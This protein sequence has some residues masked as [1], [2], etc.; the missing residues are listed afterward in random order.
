MTGSGGQIVLG[1]ATKFSND[2]GWK[3]SYTKGR[4]DWVQSPTGRVLDFQWSVSLGLTL[5]IRD[6]ASGTRRTLLVLGFGQNKCVSSLQVNGQ[7]HQFTYI[8][9]GN[10][11]RLSG[12]VPPMGNPVR[13]L[14]LADCGVLRRAESFDGKKVEESVDFQCVYVSPTDK[15]AEAPVSTDKVS[16]A[17]KA[18]AEKAAADKE[19]AEKR[20]P[21]NYQLKSDSAFDYEYAEQT[22]TK[23]RQ[24]VGQ[25]TGTS[26]TGLTISTTQS[27][28]RGI[29]TS[30]VGG[31]ETKTYF[32]KAPGQKY[33]CKLR[34][35]EVDGQLQIEHRYSRKTG[36]LSESLDA[37]GISTF[38]E[39]PANWKPARAP[40]MQPRPVRILRGSR[41]KKEVV[42]EFS[43]NEFGQVVVAKDIAGQVTVLKVHANKKHRNA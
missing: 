24:D 15:D 5:Q 9:D 3:L 11:D 26:K 30:R 16:A 17:D 33:D 18:A 2:E 38:Y 43:Y 21:K 14:Y 12:W 29:V 20:E 28:A 34:R 19:T 39:Y 4:L 35:V 41:S 37:N 22:K 42:A 7:N 27:S 32:Y 13:F 1:R 40:L 10:D 36:L 25:V 23:G 6:I 31:S 8:K